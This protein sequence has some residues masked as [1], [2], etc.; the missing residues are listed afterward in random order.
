MNKKNITETEKESPKKTSSQK[1]SRSTPKAEA[2]KKVKALREVKKLQEALK[3]AETEV[4]DLHEKYIR[5]VAELD[6]L[7][8]RTEREAQQIIRKANRQFILELL[9]ALDDLNRSLKTS[10]DSKPDD[11]RAGIE[12][13]SKKI[14]GILK[15]SGVES[16]ESLGKPFD[17]EQH[18]ALM[19]MEREGVEPGMVIEVHDEGYFLN[20]DVLR[21]AKVVVS[22]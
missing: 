11:F 9:P 18:D 8:K 10:S 3:K 14:G 4:A 5:S 15:R 20:D 13:I 16:M 2:S 22:K 19:Q 7:R 6:N 12:M 17:V 1:K 21:H